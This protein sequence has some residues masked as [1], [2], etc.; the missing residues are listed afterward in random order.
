MGEGGKGSSKQTPWTRLLHWLFSSCSLRKI[1]I[2]EGA[3]AQIAAIISISKKF[4]IPNL[5]LETRAV[6]EF[7]QTFFYSLS[8]F[9]HKSSSQ[10]ELLP[11]PDSAVAKQLRWKCA[12]TNSP[13]LAERFCNGPNEHRLKGRMV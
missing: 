13:K 7:R 10:C 6:L 9:L 4:S 2:A 12:H 8:T 11:W 5:I 3:G 1:I